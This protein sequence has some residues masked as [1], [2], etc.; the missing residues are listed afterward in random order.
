MEVPY[1]VPR[2]DKFIETKSRNGGSQRPRAWRNE[3][4]L[5]NKNF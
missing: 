5:F 3:D 4:L 1:E 2:I